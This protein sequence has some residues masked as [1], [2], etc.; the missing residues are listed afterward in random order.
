M[1]WG[2]AFPLFAAKNAAENWV[3]GILE[4]IGMSPYS[5]DLGEHITSL[6]CDCCSN[7]KKRVFG[8][9]C[10][11]GD[12]HSVYYALLN[13]TEDKPR[14]GLTVSVGPWWENT[15]PAE[16]KWIHADVWP[17]DDGVHMAL[18]DPQQSDF[19]PWE[20]G[21]IPLNPDE[22]RANE[23]IEEIWA[24]ADYIVDADPAISSYLHGADLDVRGREERDAEGA[25]HSS[26]C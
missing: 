12:A 5:L 2:I 16:R 6:R 23:L 19:Y 21:G 8:F 13:V 26:S 11:D 10:K 24:V 20:T 4:L 9:V 15:D 1:S 22:A 14:V 3:P 25:A 18:R 7:A 17:E